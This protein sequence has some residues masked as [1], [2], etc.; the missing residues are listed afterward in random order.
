MKDSLQ[1]TGKPP[2][3]HVSQNGRLGL[4]QGPGFRIDIPEDWLW[5]V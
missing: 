5:E 2:G 4:P 1:A 3:N